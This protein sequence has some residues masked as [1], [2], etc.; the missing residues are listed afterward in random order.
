MGNDR[1]NVDEICGER[2]IPGHGLECPGDEVMLGSTTD[3]ARVHRVLDSVSG[4]QRGDSG[5]YRFCFFLIVTS[6]TLFYVSRTVDVVAQGDG[7]YRSRLQ[8][9]PPPPPPPLSDPIESDPQLT[10][11]NGTA[12]IYYT[13]LSLLNYLVDIELASNMRGACPTM[14]P[15]ESISAPMAV[16]SF[17]AHR[18]HSPVLTAHPGHI[19]RLWLN[20]A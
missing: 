2:E 11:D 12:V 3:S 1:G 5:E 10:S 15:N 6:V 17:S 19:G 18:S 4:S 14:Y 20:W 8:P 9:P 7:A 16:A 13:V